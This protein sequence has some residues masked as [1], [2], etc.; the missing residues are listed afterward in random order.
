MNGTRT[1]LRAR[2]DDDWTSS[3]VS[4][5]LADEID[6]LRRDV[7]GEIADLRAEV[8]SLRRTFW[9][10][11]GALFTMAASLVAVAAAVAS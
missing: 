6:E 8:V 7:V 5:F 2:L 3:Q 4:R 10:F 1:A 9:V 11:I